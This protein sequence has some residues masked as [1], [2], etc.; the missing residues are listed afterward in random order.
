M[1]RHQ[2]LVLVFEEDPQQQDTREPFD[3]VS[4]KGGIVLPPTFKFSNEPVK[5]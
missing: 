5:R 1:R 2:G 4:S 3:K